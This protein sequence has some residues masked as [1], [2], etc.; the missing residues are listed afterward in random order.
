MHPIIK[1]PAVIWRSRAK[2]PNGARGGA[3]ISTFSLFDTKDSGGYTHFLVL[4]TPLAFK[5]SSLPFT[6]STHRPGHPRLPIVHVK[7][8]A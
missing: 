2:N 1:K 7:Y 4:H 6:P 5:F 3:R 8:P